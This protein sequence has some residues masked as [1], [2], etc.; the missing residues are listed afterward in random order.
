ML[1]F[2]T[3]W[4]DHLNHLEEVFKCLQDADLKIKCSEC[5]FFKSQIHY[6][7]FLVGTQGIQPLPEKV[8]AVE[9][10]EPPKDIIE[11]RQ[12]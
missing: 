8:I 1:I 6:L 7:G 12:F 3:M 5:K 9:A 2:S 11:L 4:Q 10:L